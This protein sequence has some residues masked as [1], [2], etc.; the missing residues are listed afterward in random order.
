MNKLDSNSPVLLATAMPVPAYKG[1]GCHLVHIDGF[2]GGKQPCRKATA[3]PN[4]SLLSTLLPPTLCPFPVLASPLF[5]QQVC[6]PLLFV[7]A[8]FLNKV[9]RLDSALGMFLF[10]LTLT[11]IDTHN[12]SP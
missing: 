7:E 3:V 9:P 12:T 11:T 8:G 1:D 6:V 5:K 2:G 4:F 10:V